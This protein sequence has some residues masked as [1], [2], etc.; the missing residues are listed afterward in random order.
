MYKKGKKFQ[1]FILEMVQL[2]KIKEA[3]FSRYAIQQKMQSI[4]SS[5]SGKYNK[6]TIYLAIFIEKLFLDLSWK[7]K[8]MKACVGGIFLMQYLFVNVVKLLNNFKKRC[9][10]WDHSWNCFSFLHFYIMIKVCFCQ[11]T[12]CSIYLKLPFCV[13]VGLDVERCIYILKFAG[14]LNDDGI[15]S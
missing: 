7:I 8:E 2:L 9:W 13:G 3:N 1:T 6:R 5:I 15:F 11:N 12:F 4:K 14:N 10:Y